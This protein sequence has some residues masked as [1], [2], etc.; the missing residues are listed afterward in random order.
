MADDEDASDDKSGVKE[1]PEKPVP[2]WAQLPDYVQ[3][4]LAASGYDAP[5]FAQQAPALR[6]TVLNL[7][8]KL[9]GLG[10]WRFVT[11]EQGSQPG[12]L[13]FCCSTVDDLKAGAARERGLHQSAALPGRL[14]LA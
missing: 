6:L 14:E 1:R 5:W 12:A 9:K 2:Q 8:V 10:L 13:N 3:S 4:E 7:Y 11:R